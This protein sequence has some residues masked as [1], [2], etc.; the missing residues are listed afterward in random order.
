M[1]RS[2]TWFPYLWCVWYRSIYIIPAITMSPSSYS[3]SYQPPLYPGYWPRQR[4]HITLFLRSLHWLSVS[5]IIHFK[6][7]LLFFKLIHNCAPQYMS[8]MLLSYVPSRSL[9]SSGTCLLTIPKPRTKRHGEADCIYY[10]HSLWNSL[11]ENLRGAET[12]DIFKRDLKTHLFS[13]AFPLGAF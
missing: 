8:D 13:F 1:E 10:A 9:K 11:S 2:Q 3:S 6:I 7:L 5:F 12:V 4:A